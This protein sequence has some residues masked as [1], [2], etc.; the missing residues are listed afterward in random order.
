MNSGVFVVALILLLSFIVLC[1]IRNKAEIA[2]KEAELMK[3]AEIILDKIKI[4]KGLEKRIKRL[5]ENKEIVINMKENRFY[6]TDDKERVDTGTSKDGG[7]G[8]D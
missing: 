7:E 4:I 6:E 5:K 8:K 2:E 3:R 1:M